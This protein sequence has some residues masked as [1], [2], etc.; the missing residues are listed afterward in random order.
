M[1]F[2]SSELTSRKLFSA[3]PPVDCGGSARTVLAGKDSLRRADARPCLLRSV[4][5]DFD[6]RRA[7]PA[8]NIS[9]TLTPI[10]VHQKDVDSAGLLME[11]A[12]NPAGGL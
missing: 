2:R 6:L 7:G 9:P 11:V 12:D 3:P 8:G 10:A 1:S 5:A 4:P